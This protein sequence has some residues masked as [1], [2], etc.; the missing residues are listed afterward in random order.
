MIIVSF[1]FW[2]IGPKDNPSDIVVA[3]V[4]GRKITQ[5]QYWKAYE[6]AERVLREK[7]GNKEEELKKMNIKEKVLNDLIDRLVLMT[8]ADEAGIKITDEELQEAI[9]SNP[10][11]QRNGAFDKG[12]YERALKLN[13]ITPKQYEDAIRE[14]LLV[15]KIYKV[16]GETAELSSKDIEAIAP[17]KEEGIQ[18]SQALLSAKKDLAVKAYIEGIKRSLKIKIN[19]EQIS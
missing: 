18:L 13:R 10:Y 14:D 4:G 3:E 15:E 9:M 7:Y 6:N 19:K 2:G 17:A 8:A 11:F 5:Q 12:I 1:V 16:A